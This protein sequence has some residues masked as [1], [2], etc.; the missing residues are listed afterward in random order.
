VDR[1][2]Q[3]IKD[4]TVEYEDQRAKVDALD[5]AE[6]A[7]PTNAHLFNIL[8]V[9]EGR[10]DAAR[11][12][13]TAAL[14]LLSNCL[15]AHSSNAQAQ[16]AATAAAALPAATNPL[17]TTTAAEK[18][19]IKRKLP[20][21]RDGFK[22]STGKLHRAHSDAM[23]YHK[24]ISAILWQITDIVHSQSIPAGSVATPTPDVPLARLVPLSTI[25]DNIATYSLGQLLEM[26][27]NHV[28]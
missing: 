6:R 14:A 18:K 5:A 27:L 12:R 22:D 8:M 26:G 25:E 11:T 3:E 9:R 21:P 7:D 20:E 10:L 4:Y 28:H 13:E 24:A 2:S 17:T 15:I 1:S 19:N 16:A 23:S